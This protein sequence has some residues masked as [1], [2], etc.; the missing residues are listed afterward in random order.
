MK[1]RCC[2]PH[3]S[4]SWN[5]NELEPSRVTDRVN[6]AITIQLAW[7]KYHNECFAALDMESVTRLFLEVACMLLCDWNNAMLADM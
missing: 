6:F 4:S 2:P 3:S 1:V 7:R 5:S